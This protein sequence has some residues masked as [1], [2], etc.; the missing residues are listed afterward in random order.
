MGLYLGRKQIS[1]GLIAST[2][3]RITKVLKDHDKVGFLAYDIWQGL[4]EEFFKRLQAWL[5]KKKK[6]LKPR[7]PRPHQKEAIRDAV[8]YFK[9]R[10]NSRGKL[11]MP[12]G[13]GKSLTSFFIAEKLKAQRVL[14]AVPSLSLIRQTLKE[15]MRESLARNHKVEWICVCSDESAGKIDQDDA[16]VLTQDLGVPCLTD[17]KQISSWLKRKHSFRT[18]VF[19]TYQSGQA[20]A[21]ACR[22]AEFAFDLGVMDEAHKTAGAKDRLFSHLILD[23]NI[24]I[25][26]RLFMTATER[27][28]RGES[29]EILSMEDPD[30][31]GE[32]IHKLSF[33]KALD[34][35]PPILSDYKVITIHISKQDIAELARNRAFVLPRIKGWSKKIDAANL[36]ALIALRKAIKKYPIR[37]AVSFH[38]SI[39]RAQE[40]KES[41]DAYNKTFHVEQDLKTFHVSS[42]TPTGT[43]AKEINYFS[44]ASRG[45]ITNARCLTEG[46]D[47]PNIDAVLFADPRKSLVDIVQ[48]VGR[49]LRPYPQKKFGYVIVPVVHNKSSKPEEVFESETFKEVLTTLRALAS[50]DDR[51]IEYFRLLAKESRNGSFK[52]LEDCFSE[53]I[54]KK[55]NLKKFTNSIQLKCWSKLGKLSWLPF[56]EARKYVRSLKLSG[57]KEWNLFY[58]NRLQHVPKIPPDIPAAPWQVYKGKGWISMGDWLGTGNIHRNS[59]KYFPFKKARSFVRKIG[60]KSFSEWRKYCLGKIKGHPQPLI[61]IPRAPQNVYKGKGW[62]SMGD[63]LGTGVVAT[64]LRKYLSYKKAEKIV[65]KLKLK[66]Q[67]AYYKIKQAGKIKTLDKIPNGPDSVYRNKGWVSWN[68]WLGTKARGKRDLLPF[69]K[70]RSI[71]RKKGFKSQKEFFL[72]CR[73]KIKRYGSLPNNIPATPHSSYKNKGWKGYGDWLGTN[74]LATTKRPYWSYKKCSKFLQKKGFI[75]QKEFLAFTKTKEFRT[76]LINYIPYSPYKV[77]K[78]E[79]TSWGAY[80][81]TG[82]VASYNRKYLPFRAARKIV[83]KLKLRSTR[84]WKKACEGYKYNKAKIPQTIPINP[85]PIYLSKGWKGFGDWLGTGNLSPY[86]KLRSFNDAKKWAIKNNISTSSEWKKTLREMGKAF[87]SDIPR[88]PDLV[89]KGAGWKGWPQFLCS[90]KISPNRKVC[91]FVKTKRFAKKH[92]IQTSTQ[93]RE[94]FKKI[95]NTE[96]AEIPRAP[97]LVYA[98]Q[99]K[100]HGWTSFLRT[101]KT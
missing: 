62:V 17:P 32:T 7:L 71:I 47:I 87:P 22:Y 18:I 3:E 82:N 69:K 26:R 79:W 67:N 97:H 72:F 63:W 56:E 50:Q 1:F 94:F 46:V 41:N 76:K 61:E 35:K 55:I 39:K 70:A 42:K 100:W 89:Y 6:P 48:S 38:G 98:R 58:T 60:L 30:D 96:Y 44:Q 31:Y 4:D 93:W 74:T 13:T 95:K 84:D 57:S 15:W 59:F 11:I 86:R 53:F 14:I 28:Y 29:D 5:Y 73:G 80:L 92:N 33:K 37:H 19:T 54:A 64:S 75:K 12:C 25:A 20:L 2:T 81:G 49:A 10:G 51:I 36:A 27:R 40:F 16:V 91:S 88:S 52:N 99:N 68:K 78:K 101:S 21:K 77:F 8:A 90:K 9:K 24:K 65:K 34:Y 66:N 45:L 23:K 85:K 43:R 83:H